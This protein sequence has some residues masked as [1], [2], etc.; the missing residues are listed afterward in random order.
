MPSQRHCLY[1]NAD[2]WL[3]YVNGEA[4]RLPILDALLADSASPKGNVEL[5]T[6]VISEVEVAFGKQEQDKKALDPDIEEQIDH[7]WADRN[8]VKI[9]E[10]H[11]AIGKE[12][13]ELMRLGITKGWSLKP[14]DAIHLATAKHIKCE[15]FHT[16]D[17]RL[18]K[19]SNEVGFPIVKPHTLQA[20]FGV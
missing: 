1:W 14:L 3:A 11:E 17:D 10:Y 5:Y 19:Y 8:A 15:E 7:L 4:D 16:Y 9:V 6:S 20:R 18:L 13:R 12:A 2:V